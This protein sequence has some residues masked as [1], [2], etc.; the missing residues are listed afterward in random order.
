MI[1]AGFRREP[2]FAGG[3]GGAIIGDPISVRAWGSDKAAVFGAN[4]VF[5]GPF[6]VHEQSHG[7]FLSSFEVIV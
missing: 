2:T 4:A 7:V 5:V 1:A 3:A 6:T